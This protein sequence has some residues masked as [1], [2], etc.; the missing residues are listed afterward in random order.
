[1]N[2]KKITIKIDPVG[3]STVDAEGFVGG[4]CTDAT[5]ALEEALG[6]N[7]DLSERDLKSSYYE[8]EESN[9]EL[10]LS[11]PNFAGY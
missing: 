4:T 1:M 3:R 8:Q 10:G 5:K 7:P 11:D 2:Q 9:V 6:A